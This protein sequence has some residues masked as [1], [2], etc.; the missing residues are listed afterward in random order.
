[1]RTTMTIAANYNCTPFDVM[2]QD[3][4]DVL[5]LLNFYVEMANENDTPVQA[6]TQKST[7]EKRIRVND[8]TATGGWW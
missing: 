2:N 4:D 8:K 6:Q 7:K 5:L 1:M 3:I